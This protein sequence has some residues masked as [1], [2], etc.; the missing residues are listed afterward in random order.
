LTVRVAIVGPAHPYKG[1]A[2]QHTTE[3]AHR[4]A[5]AGHEVALESWHAQYPRLLYPGQ[6]TV[7]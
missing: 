2:A 6:L 7:D 5:A 4:M 3:L 1:G